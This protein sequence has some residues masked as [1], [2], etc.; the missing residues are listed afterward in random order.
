MFK[1]EKDIM[2]DYSD[3]QEIQSNNSS[4][5]KFEHNKLPKIKR[6]INQKKKIINSQDN[7]IINT[8]FKNNNINGQKYKYK[9]PTRDFHKTQTHVTYHNKK[10][11]SPIY[12]RKKT[13]INDY[14]FKDYKTQKSFYIKNSENTIQ[15]NSSSKYFNVFSTKSLNAKSFKTIRLIDSKTSNINNNNHRRSKKRKPT[16]NL[17]KENEINLDDKYK[18]ILSNENNIYI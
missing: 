16:L 13:D 3:C 4:F 7:R 8:I 18:L 2:E 14:L 15:Q 10:H 6:K 12:F 17:E 9:S 1:I 5:L 11:K